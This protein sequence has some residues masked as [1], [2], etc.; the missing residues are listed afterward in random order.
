MKTANALNKTLLSFRTNDYFEK[1]FDLA[2]LNANKCELEPVENSMHIKKLPKRLQH[3]N[4][5]AAQLAP[6][7]T[8]KKLTT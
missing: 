2:K 7:C 4:N 5:P 8:L 6:K 1:M 3:S